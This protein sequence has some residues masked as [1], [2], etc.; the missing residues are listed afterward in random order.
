MD[1]SKLN[2][3]SLRDKISNKL[4]SL[5]GSKNQKKN[6][7]AS[8]KDDKSIKVNETKPKDSEKKLKKTEKSKVG[9]SEAEV[10]RRE[11]LA[12]GATEEDLA[13]LSGVEEGEDSEQE[14]D[15]SDAKLDKAFGDDLTNFMKGIGLGL[16]LIHI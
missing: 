13:M 12:L 6:K 4:G 1:T 7:R 10:L 11:A 3:S 8:G 15:V 5:A 16:S 14:F 2:L 9:E